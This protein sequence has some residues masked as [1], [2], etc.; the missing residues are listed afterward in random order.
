MDDRTKSVLTAWSDSIVNVGSIGSEIAMSRKRLAECERELAFTEAQHILSA[1]GSN[2]PMRKAQA[3][4][5]ME[6][7]PKWRRL[8]ERETELKF[9]I[10]SDEVRLEVMRNFSR[11]QR[12]MVDLLIAAG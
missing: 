2:E 3:R 6:N 10:T 7:D 8:Q 5:D 12:S 1:K 9:T 4:L 11:M